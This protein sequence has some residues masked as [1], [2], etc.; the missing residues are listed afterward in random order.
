[1]NSLDELKR[2]LLRYPVLSC[3][4]CDGP[5]TCFGRYEHQQQQTT[6]ACDQCCGHGNE[7]GHCRQLVNTILEALSEASP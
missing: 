3:V 2:L 7:D 1:V 5:A 4:F 6:F